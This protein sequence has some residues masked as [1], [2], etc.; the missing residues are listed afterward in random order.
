MTDNPVF[1]DIDAERAILGAVLLDNTCIQDI[2]NELIASD[3]YVATNAQLWSMIVEMADKKIPVDMISLTDVIRTRGITVDPLYLSDL[4][5]G[6]AVGDYSVAHLPRYISIVKDKSIKRK[7]WRINTASAEE[8]KRGQ[9]S[10]K[11]IALDLEEDGLGCCIEY[12][13]WRLC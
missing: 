4:T 13:S 2:R 9:K 5:H 7:L 11:D 8:L 10:G 1:Y 12:G 6:V 3:F